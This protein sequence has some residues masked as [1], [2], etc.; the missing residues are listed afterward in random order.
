[1][2][3]RYLMNHPRALPFLFLTEVWERFGFYINHGLLVLYMTEYFGYSDGE[4]YLILGI[5]TALVYI[6]P[7]LGGYVANRFLGFKTSIVW[8]GLFLV[9]GYGLLALPH[10]KSWLYLALA[11]VIV[12]NGLFK[13]NISSLLGLQYD[14]EDSRRDAGFTIFY[15]GINVGSFLAGLS[16]GYIRLYFGWHLSYAI[17]SIGIFIG[18]ATFLFGYKYLRDQIVVQERKHTPLIFVCT[19]FVI[20][21]IYY[22]MRFHGVADKILPV[23]GILILAGLIVLTLKQTGAWR[24]KMLVLNVL[25]ISGVSFWTMYFQMFY[26]ANLFVD[27]FVE[28]SFLGIPLTTTIFYASEAVFL[29]MLGPIFAY[30]WNKLAEKNINPSPI[31]KFILGLAFISLAFFILSFSTHFANDAGMIEAWWVFLS[32]SMITIGELLLSPIG[33]SAITLF[34]PPTLLGLMMGVWFVSLGYGG[35]FAGWIAQFANIPSDALS[36]AAKLEIYRNAFMDYSYIGVGTVI[37]LILTYGI[38][39]KQLKHD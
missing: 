27:R 37:L 16:S 11:I 5:F 18:L 30:L 13:P 15:I 25:V 6:S 17:A 26:S 33:L 29:I 28:K 14:E 9:L 1:M 32:Y 22:L 2:N 4:S 35:M 20:G 19:L 3:N 12:G 7:L 23:A 34:S 10:A 31:A 39:Y 8:G 36:T 24:T 21:V 38:F